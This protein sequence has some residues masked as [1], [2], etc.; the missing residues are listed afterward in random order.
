MAALDRRTW[1]EL[2][3]E[4][5]TRL[6]NDS[7][8]TRAEEWLAA[9]HLD[10]ALLYHH[11]ELDTFDQSLVASTANPFVTLPADCYVV[12]GVIIRDVASGD[13]LASLEPTGAHF[14]F[15]RYNGTTGEPT[16][17]SRWGNRLW[18]DK[19]PTQAHPIDL[20][21][22]AL[23]AAPDFAGSASP[24]LNQLWDEHILDGAVA[25]AQGCLWRPEIAGVHA[26]MLTDF[27]QRVVQRPLLELPLPEE[28]LARN[29]GR[30][31]GGPQG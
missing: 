9:V 25:R 13:I 18:F 22:Y 6:G 23:P 8:T 15:V 12:V 27:L 21:Y 30:H 31:T 5:L 20:L 11:P 2:R 17:Y 24:A 19:L 4:L 1:A 10:L 14:S 7:L 29:L 16:K 3:T 28:P 26:D